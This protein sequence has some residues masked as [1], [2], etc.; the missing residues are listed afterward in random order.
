MIDIVF[1]AYREAEKVVISI[2]ARVIAEKDKTVEPKKN[3]D[4]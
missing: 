4:R 3:K 2:L 1:P